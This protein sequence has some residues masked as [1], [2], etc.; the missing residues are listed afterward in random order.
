[1][2]GTS[3]VVAA[4]A[5]GD[6]TQFDNPGHI[7]LGAFVAQSII[8]TTVWGAGIGALVKAEKWERLSV[9]PTLTVAAA[10]ISAGLSIA[11]K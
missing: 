5:I 10:T 4:L 3:I 6:R 9:H 7:S 1:M 11:L 2:I 8:A